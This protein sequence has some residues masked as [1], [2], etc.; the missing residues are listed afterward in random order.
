M[1]AK[2]ETGRDLAINNQRLAVLWFYFSYGSCVQVAEIL[3]RRGSKFHTDSA[4]MNLPIKGQL[5][6]SIAVFKILCNNPLNVTFQCLLEVCMVLVFLHY[7][8]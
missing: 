4:I 3:E 6:V 5:E 8:L 2:K 1:E 7:T